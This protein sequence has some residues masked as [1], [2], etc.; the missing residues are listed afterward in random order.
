MLANRSYSV[1]I[2][3]SNSQGSSYLPKMLRWAIPFLRIFIF[4]SLECRQDRFKLARYSIFMGYKD[5]HMIIR[6]KKKQT[7]LENKKSP[8]GAGRVGRRGSSCS[9]I[10]GKEC[11]LPTLWTSRWGAK[12]TSTSKQISWYQHR[13][14]QRFPSWVFSSQNVDHKTHSAE[15]VNDFKYSEG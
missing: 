9:D 7:K 14:Q 10:H 8:R 15:W 11:W 1:I 3:W 2:M 12:S 6:N 13:N 4:I 5:Y